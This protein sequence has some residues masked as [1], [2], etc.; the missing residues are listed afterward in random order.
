M[1]ELQVEQVSKCQV[2]NELS[3]LRESPTLIGVLGS[4]IQAA[5]CE[6]YDKE[7]KLFSM[8]GNELSVVFRFGFYLNK[9]IED[10][11]P[12]AE[13]VLD[14][15]YNKHGDDPKKINSKRNKDI[16]SEHGIRPDLV[17]HQRGTDKNN[18]LIIECKRDESNNSI[19]FEKLGL[20]TASQTLA[21]YNYQYKYGC[22]INFK[23]DDAEIIFFKDGKQMN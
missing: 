18:I 3:Q 15:E 14:A 1:S 12:N 19:D 6:L 4:L 22:Y 7:Y 5:K 8:S 16:E 20:M 13:I 23:K 9:L 11:F 21:K 2:M 10:K 17:L